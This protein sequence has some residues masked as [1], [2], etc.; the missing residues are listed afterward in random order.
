VASACVA[1]A[2]RLSHGLAGPW[3]ARYAQGFSLAAAGPPTGLHAPRRPGAKPP[4]RGP[5]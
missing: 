5:G 3:A 2:C 1:T 4:P